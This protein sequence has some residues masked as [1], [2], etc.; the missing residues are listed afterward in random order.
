MTHL[1]LGSS[2]EEPWGG[3]LG[4]GGGVVFP[5]G[6]RSLL[7]RLGCP[8]PGGCLLLCLEA[9]ECLLTCP[10]WVLLE[11]WGKLLHL[12]CGMCEAAWEELFPS[13]EARRTVTWE[14]LLPLPEGR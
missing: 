6:G 5:G 2:L 3:L 12:L 8:V 1:G 4:G 13:P 7:G 9:L 10:A 14:E 11:A